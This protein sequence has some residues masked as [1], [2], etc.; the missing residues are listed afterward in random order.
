M[1]MRMQPLR[2]SLHALRFARCSCKR[3]SSVIPFC[4]G[5]AQG[6]PAT[7]QADAAPAS[8]AAPSDTPASSD[9]GASV[10]E[11][12]QD[13]TA[14][15]LASLQQAVEPKPSVKSADPEVNEFRSLVAEV[16][17]NMKESIATGES[18]PVGD[19]AASATPQQGPNGGALP[20]EA[21]A[22][23]NA[24]QGKAVASSPAEGCTGLLGQVWRGVPHCLHKPTIT[25][26]AL[27]LAALNR[28]DCSTS[29]RPASACCRPSQSLPAVEVFLWSNAAD[30]QDHASR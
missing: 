20:A 5:C 15:A 17:D 12:I 7:G 19:S 1:R 8:K 25:H 21:G 6:A 30:G 29:C 18:T 2:P 3:D 4:A 9:G 26:D 28:H 22:A 10:I 23:A 16:F 27:Q 13:K 14:G 11:Q 24:A